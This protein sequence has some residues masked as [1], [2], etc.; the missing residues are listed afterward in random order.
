MYP[1]RV[2]LKWDVPGT[3]RDGSP[4]KDIS[5]FKVYRTAQKIG[6]EC[7]DCEEQKKSPINIDFQNPSNA[8]ITDGEVVYTD[9]NIAPENVYAYSITVY[10][11]AGREG[12]PSDEVTVVYDVPPP[13]PAEL[14]S[15]I[16]SKGIRLEWTPPGRP[17]GL[18]SYRVYRGTTDKPEDMKPIGNT[19]WAETYFLDS[20]AEREKTYYYQVRSLKMNKGISLESQPSDTVSATIPPLHTTPPENVNT[21]AISD[22]IRIFWHAVPLEGSQTRYNIYRSESG[23]MFERINREP[24]ANPLFVDKNVRRGKTYRYGVTAFPAGKPDDESSRSGSE[25][26]TFNP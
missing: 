14:R 2:I 16:D 26:V 11:L 7:K 25:A 15:D 17:A 3:N 13:A 19:R 23:K 8:V 18:R 20:S 1:G 6:E 9:T 24:L 21:A 4:L 22:G 12:G 5:G 10:N